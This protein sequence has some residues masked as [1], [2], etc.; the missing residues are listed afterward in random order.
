MMAK[1]NIWDLIRECVCSVVLIHQSNDC[2]VN[3]QESMIYT[4]VHTMHQQHTFS[5]YHARIY[6]FLD[7]FFLK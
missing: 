3:K 4:V 6:E 7:V 5:Y 1:S 2:E